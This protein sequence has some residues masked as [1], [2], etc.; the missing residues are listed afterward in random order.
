MFKLNLCTLGG[1]GGCLVMEAPEL[2]FFPSYSAFVPF[3][4]NRN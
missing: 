1:Q 4:T 2:L 3:P